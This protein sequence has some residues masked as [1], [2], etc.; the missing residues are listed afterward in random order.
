MW[1]MDAGIR[2]WRVIHDILHRRVLMAVAVLT[3]LCLTYLSAAVLSTPVFM[4]YSGT[5]FRAKNWRC[6]AAAVAVIKYPS[7]LLVIKRQ[8][9]GC[10]CGLHLIILRYIISI[11]TLNAF[12]S[13]SSSSSSSSYTA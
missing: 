7:P 6:Y 13:S 10:G 9:F 2:A 1:D 11:I 8:S 12:S 4:C 5:M 3:L